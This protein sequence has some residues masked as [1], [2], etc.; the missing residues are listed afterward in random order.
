MELAPANA[1][2]QI[3]RVDLLLELGEKK[4]AAKALDEMVER[5]TPRGLLRQWYKKCGK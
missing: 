1:D 4:A 3:S 2:Y 5:G